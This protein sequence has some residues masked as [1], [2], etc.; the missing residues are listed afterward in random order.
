MKLDTEKFR[1]AT[2]KCTQTEIAAHFGIRLHPPHSLVL[3]QNYPNSHF[4]DD[5]HQGK[6]TPSRFAQCASVELPHVRSAV[7]SPP[8]AARWSVS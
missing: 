5:V 1:K 4:T 7:Q 2:R 3:S 8:A 6:Q